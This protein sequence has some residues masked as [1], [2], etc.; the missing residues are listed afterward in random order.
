MVSFLSYLSFSKD[1][2]V[3]LHSLLLSYLAVPW[4]SR[5]GVRTIIG[6]SVKLLAL[7]VGVVAT[8]VLIT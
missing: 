8:D 2:Q 7:V 1:V 6:M 3:Y 5:I 4:L